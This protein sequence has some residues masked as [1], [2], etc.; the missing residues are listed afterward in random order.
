MEKALR[1]ETLRKALE[2]MTGTAAIPLAGGTDLMVRYKRQGGL[3]PRFEKPVLFIGHLK[4]LALIVE[5]KGCVSIG[6]CS[7]YS[8]LLKESRVPEVLRTCMGNIAAPAIRNRGT[9]GGNICNASPAGDTIPVL[10]ALGASVVLS[11]GKGRRIMLVDEF[12]TGPGT[13][14]REEDE[15]L[16]G[17]IVPGERFDFSFYRKVGTRRYD[18]LSKVSFVGL[19]KREGERVADVR[20][21]FGAVAPT[22]VRSKETE[23]M[24]IGTSLKDI[25]PIIPDICSRYEKLITPIDDQRSTKK[26]RKAVSLRLLGHFLEQCTSGL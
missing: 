6:P 8:M 23:D 12:I 5:G 7:T 14:V 20:L 3:V 21:A 24:I 9:I 13:T 25:K 1:P 11:R 19:M 10:S 16:T 18:S 26:Y 22:V 17:V 2:L 4:D 15:L